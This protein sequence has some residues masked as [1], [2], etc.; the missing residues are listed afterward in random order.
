MAKMKKILFEKHGF[1]IPKPFVIIKN[2]LKDTFLA[3]L[4]VKI[5]LLMYNFYNKIRKGKLSE[6]GI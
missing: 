1:K 5:N 6:Q 4:N 2:K 3:W